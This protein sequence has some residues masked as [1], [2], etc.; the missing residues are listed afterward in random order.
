MPMD[1][2]Q[3]RGILPWG[4]LGPRATGGILCERQRQ[5]LA[6]QRQVGSKPLSPIPRTVCLSKRLRL[7]V[8]GEGRVAR[9]PF[10]GATKG[11]IGVEG[12]YPVLQLGVGVAHE[13]GHAAVVRRIQAPGGGPWGTRPISFG[14][15]IIGR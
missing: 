13:L 5:L 10:P 14:G 7:E 11:P 1:D 15:K 3:N 4:S 9:L 12:A 2:E 8:R 6:G